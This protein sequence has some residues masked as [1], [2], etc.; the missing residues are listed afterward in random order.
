MMRELKPGEVPGKTW[1]INVWV[2][3]N[4]KTL[5]DVPPFSKELQARLD[6]CSDAIQKS[7][8]ELMDN[9][10]MGMTPEKFVEMLEKVVL[11]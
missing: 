2:D 6:K 1:K 11:K 10:R 5:Y 8:A 9:T 3:L 4:I 7:L